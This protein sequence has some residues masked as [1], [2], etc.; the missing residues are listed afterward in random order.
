MRKGFA[1]AALL[2]P[3]VF[4]AVALGQIQAVSVLSYDPGETSELRLESSAALGGITTDTGPSWAVNPFNSPFSGDDIVVIGGGGHL[5]L[6]L[7][8]AIP[9]NG[10]HLGV[11]ST[12]GYIDLEPEGKGL[13]GNPPAPFTK[14][15]GAIVS[16]SADGDDWRLLNNGQVIAFANPTNAF[17]D[18]DVDGWAQPIGSAPAN[19]AKPFLGTPD[20]LAGLNYGQIRTTL[21]GSAGGDWLDLSSAGLAS[22]SYVRFDVP[23]GGG[24]MAID[25]ISGLPAA[26]PVVAG[27]SIISLSVGEG[28]NTSHIVIDFGPQS[29]QF[30][31]HYDDPITGLEAL[32]LLDSETDFDVML[33]DTPYGKQVIGH[34][35][36]GYAF[37]SDG[38]NDSPWWGYYVGD[39]EG[40]SFAGTGPSDRWLTDG[41]LDGWVWSGLQETAPDFPVAVPEPAALTLLMAGAL[42]LRRRG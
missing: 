8:E 15:W 26:K 41:S 25:A 24:E 14:P 3:Q 13:M 30:E 4:G 20:D 10:R 2:A 28:A 34:D 6:Q 32:Q 33:K 36:G 16:V 11:F 22:V 37:I 29:Y 40:W 38:L 7:S 18:T 12:N 23:V 39:G 5:T 42:L 27:E 21:N 31:V 35:F 9:A 17:L 1:L 19:P